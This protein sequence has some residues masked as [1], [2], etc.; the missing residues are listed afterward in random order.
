MDVGLALIGGRQLNPSDES[1]TGDGNVDDWW[2]W[3]WE[4][5]D[6]TTAF[7]EGLATLSSVSNISLPFVSILTYIQPSTKSRV[8]TSDVQH[9]TDT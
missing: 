4:Y 9:G 3:V 6:I 1:F 2:R 8:H 5:P 7:R